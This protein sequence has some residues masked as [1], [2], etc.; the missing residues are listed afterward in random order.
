M[1]IALNLTKPL[2]HVAVIMD[3]NGRWAKLRGLPRTAGHKAGVERIY[4]IADA[5]K[6]FNI[7]AMSLY[8]FSTENWNRPQDEIDF[9]FS[10]IDIFFKKY[11]KTAHKD[12]TRIIVSGDIS[13]L[14]LKVQKTLNKA[15]DETKDYNRFYFNVCLNYGSYAEL[16]KATKEIAT[17]VKDNKL[18][19]NDIN[20]ETINNH[21]YTKDL[22]PVDLLIR[23]SG[24][25]RLSNFMLFQLAY[26]E[27]IF[28]D[29]YWP[30][31][32]KEEFIKCL[33]IYNNR[34]RRYGGLK[35]E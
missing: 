18:D 34:N 27:F 6:E 7:K 3:G 29:T 11:I 15:T 10:Y 19:I 12:Q 21:L 28:S 1:S 26:S 31:F 25:V 2:N 20:S 22:P 14:P 17:L 35:N 33:N 32:S 9:L 30:D 16:V 4:E 5:C 24:E 8:A 23:T 13:R